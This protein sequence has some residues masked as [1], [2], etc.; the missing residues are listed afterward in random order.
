MRANINNRLRYSLQLALMMLTLCLSTTSMAAADIFKDF[1]PCIESGDCANEA[2]DTPDEEVGQIDSEIPDNFGSGDDPILV[3][4]LID[5]GTTPDDDDENDETDPGENEETDPGENDEVVEEDSDM[6]TV[7]QPS[8]ANIFIPADDAQQTNPNCNTLGCRGGNLVETPDDTD[9]STEDKKC[10][11]CEA[12]DV[13]VD[14]NKAD[15]LCGGDG[16]DAQ[17]CFTC[18]D[19]TCAMPVCNASDVTHEFGTTTL[20]YV[21]KAVTDV[22]S[23]LNR[24]P[25]VSSEAQPFFD[26]KLTSGKKCC[27]TCE[28]FKPEGSSYKKFA[29][30]AGLKGP[31][32][33]SLL[34][35][36]PKKVQP[37]K[38]L[39][40]G[41]YFGGEIFISPVAL[42]TDLKLSGGADYTILEDC[43]DE[44]CGSFSLGWSPQLRIGPRVLIEAKLMSCD[45]P[46]CED[47]VVII[48]GK[49]GVEVAAV[50]SGFVGGKYSSGDHCGANCLGGK[51]N[52]IGGLVKG[53]FEV[54]IL[55]KTYELKYEKQVEIFDGFI[56]GEGL[57]CS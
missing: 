21:V 42:T 14:A 17:A 4:D 15:Q 7:D 38:K 1:I 36:P 46:S 39:G 33:V 29:G 44:N 57:N 48:G 49:L 50:I 34:G 55:F 12:G 41:Y 11:T 26:I 3:V 37:P 9:I 56:F 2:G 54:E 20:D 18:Q 43:G 25:I 19:G 53:A 13:V 40:F 47:D 8:L 6:C 28:N 23:L 31:V 22:S 45:S 30:E 35:P 52:P 10:N 24:I 32:K 5:D 51:I 27:L 16:T